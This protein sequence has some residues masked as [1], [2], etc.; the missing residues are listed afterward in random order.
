M[1]SSP[2]SLPVLVVSL[3]CLSFA[4]A[5][6][7]V[8]TSQPPPRSVDLKVA[9]GTLLKTT[10]FAASKP[11]PGMLLLHQSNRDRKSWAGI[12]AQLASAGI[13]TLTF[14]MRGMGE[15]GGSRKDS[16]RIP[17]DVDSALK[18]AAQ[19]HRTLAG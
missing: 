13:N 19:Y 9:D 8:Q 2:F 17:D 7:E 4:T 11:G 14:D 12:A 5:H 15:S 18:R 1:P 6:A 10:Y 16:E 3:S